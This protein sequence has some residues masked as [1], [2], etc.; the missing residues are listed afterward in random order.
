CAVVYSELTT[1]ILISHIYTIYDIVWRMKAQGLELF[2]A[3]KYM[4][5]LKFYRI[6]CSIFCA[7]GQLGFIFY[8]FSFVSFNLDLPISGHIDINVFHIL[9]IGSAWFHHDMYAHF[10]FS[11]IFPFFVNF[12]LLFT[13]QIFFVTRLAIFTCFAANVARGL[14]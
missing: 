3:W 6:V 12:I 5:I 1:I 11:F 4:L 14:D 2:Q 8:A 10:S 7:F 9:C 13:L